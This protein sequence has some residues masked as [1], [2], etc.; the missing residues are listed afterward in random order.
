MVRY[1]ALPVFAPYLSPQALVVIDDGRR[2]D[3]TRMVELW[4][5]LG[6]QFEAEPLGFLPRA[7][8]L[9][10]MG[11]GSRTANIHHFR[12]EERPPESERDTS[13]ERRNAS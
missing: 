9:V 4:R 13:G 10:T 2:E 6:V 5:E 1:P 8:V 7:P 12:A 11:G 3:E